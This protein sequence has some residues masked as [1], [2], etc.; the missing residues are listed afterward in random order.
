MIGNG[1]MKIGKNAFYGCR[2]LVEFEVSAENPFYKSVSGLLLTKDGTTLVGGVNGDVVVPDGVTSIGDRSFRGLRLLT[3][4]T[5]PA[6]VTSIGTSVFYG[7]SKLEEFVVAD[8]NPAYKSV[9]GLLLT[10]DGKTLVEG[11]NGDVVIP[12][13]VTSIGDYA[14][15]GCSG[16]TS[17][18]IP[19]SVTSI[20][21]RA[22]YNCSG[23]T[24]MT[25]PD[26]VVDV[27]DDAFEGCDGLPA[28]VKY[29]GIVGD[30]QF[31]KAQKK[32]G[33]LYDATDALVGTVE[34]K[35][36]KKSKK[37][38]GNV[39]DRREVE[40]DNRQGDQPSGGERQVEHYAGVRYA[41]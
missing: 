16:L 6:S 37:G 19:E 31:G 10:K 24:N 35:F 8:D 22:F 27:A 32:V 5:I 17:V 14:F 34:L 18:T 20:G 41:D 33:T 4:V 21:E 36:S 29:G 40:E 30:V 25:I 39:A 26:G 23:L 28:N 3:S 13:G 1:V 38:G 9:S 7:C 12:D 15:S 11:V 2:E